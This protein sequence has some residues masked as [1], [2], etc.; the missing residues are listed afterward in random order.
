MSQSCGQHVLWA[1]GAQVLFPSR[2][3]GAASVPHLQK[4]PSVG[5]SGGHGARENLVSQHAQHGLDA[6]R[7]EGALGTLRDARRLRAHAQ[8]ALH[9]I[10]APHR[11]QRVPRAGLLDGAEDEEA[12]LERDLDGAARHEPLRRRRRK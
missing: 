10:H 11:R 1:Q 3:C 4:P 2:G 7:A 5:G 6:R 12:V 8:A 9:L